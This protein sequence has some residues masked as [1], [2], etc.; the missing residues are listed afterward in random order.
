MW[1]FKKKEV[2]Y[3]YKKQF[4][5]KDYTIELSAVEENNNNG[6]DTGLTFKVS[7]SVAGK[8]NYTITSLD[9]LKTIL[10]NGFVSCTK[11]VDFIIN[12]PV[13]LNELKERL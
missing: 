10:D 9:N 7:W 11:Y 3:F 12:K 13:V 2:K 1:S 8:G 5:Y 6:L 4:L